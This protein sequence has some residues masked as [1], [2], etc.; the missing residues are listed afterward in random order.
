MTLS[1]FPLA[2]IKIGA[3]QIFLAEKRVA[4]FGHN[5]HP[6]MGCLPQD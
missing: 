2:R 4:P 6:H 3:Y 1:V 5:A